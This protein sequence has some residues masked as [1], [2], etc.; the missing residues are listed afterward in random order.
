MERC[1]QMKQRLISLENISTS[2]RTFVYH[3]D[4]LEDLYCFMEGEFY[5]FSREKFEIKVSPTRMGSLLRK[6]IEGETIPS[7]FEDLY[8]KV[9]SRKSIPKCVEISE[10]IYPTGLLECGKTAY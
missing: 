10:K 4:T 1:R 3:A 8:I 6:F 5:W 2:P 9:V 7:E